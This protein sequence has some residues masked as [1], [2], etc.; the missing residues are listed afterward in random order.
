MRARSRLVDRFPCWLVFVLRLAAC[1]EIL[2]HWL[3][4]SVG[5]ALLETNV[6]EESV[7]GWFAAEELDQ[8]DDTVLAAACGEN[9]VAIL[10]LSVAGTL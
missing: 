2:A 7:L 4:R 5:D 1:L 9:Q 6:R 8:V 10:L 3:H